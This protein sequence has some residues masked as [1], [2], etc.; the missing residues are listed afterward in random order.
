M[1]VYDTNQIRNIAILGHLGS[2]KTSI[3]EALL[4]SSGAISSRGSV[5]AKNTVS[6]FMDEEK[7]KQGSLSSRLGPYVRT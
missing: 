1:K 6:D 5:E 2:G 7:A 4:F 3:A